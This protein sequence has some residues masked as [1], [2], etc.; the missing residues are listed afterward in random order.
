MSNSLQPMNCNMPGLPV[1]HQFPAFTQTHVHRVSDAIQPSNPL[2]SPS[3]T[4]NLSQHQG[5]FPVSQFFASG[6]QN[7]KSFSFNISPSNEYSELISFRMNWFISC[8]TF[9]IFSLFLLPLTRTSRKLF[10]SNGSYCYTFCY[11]EIRWCATT[12]ACFQVL[13]F[14]H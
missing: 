5:L 13:S 1:H 10:N 14:G 11:L 3:P 2:L 12:A 7:I 8:Y 6:S 9:F 4:F